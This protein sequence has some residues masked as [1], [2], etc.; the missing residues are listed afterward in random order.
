MYLFI[1]HSAQGEV[2]QQK[3]ISDEDRSAVEAGDLAIIQVVGSIS[4]PK[5]ESLETISTEECD[6]DGEGTGDYTYED[7]WVS[8]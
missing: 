8:V 4:N 2:S 5:F 3:T 6:E 1:D 7:T